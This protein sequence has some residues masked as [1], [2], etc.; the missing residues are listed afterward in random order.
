MQ[1]CP[2][3]VDVAG[4]VETERKGVKD[5]AKGKAFIENAKRVEM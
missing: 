3:G 2:F 4:G 5:H 1:I